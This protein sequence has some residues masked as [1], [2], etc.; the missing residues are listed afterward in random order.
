VKEKKMASKK[1]MLERVYENMQ[2][3]LDGEH[4]FST[5]LTNFTEE[6]K[7]ILRYHTKCLM[8]VALSIQLLVQMEEGQDNFKLLEELSGKFNA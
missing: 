4:L 5:E 1:E 8:S 7:Q 2:A 3:L 6:Q